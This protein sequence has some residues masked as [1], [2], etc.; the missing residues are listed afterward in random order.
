MNYRERERMQ[1]SWNE[2]MLE[3]PTLPRYVSPPW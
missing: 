3:F 2:A 1:G